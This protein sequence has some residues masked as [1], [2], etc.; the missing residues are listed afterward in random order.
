[1]VFA[2][3]AE[4]ALL[5]HIRTRALVQDA[6]A[7]SAAFDSGIF[8][9]RDLI[10]AEPGLQEEGPKHRV[11]KVKQA[12]LHARMDEITDDWAPRI[13]A[14]T[15]FLFNGTAEV[16]MADPVLGALK[17]EITTLVMGASQEFKSLFEKVAL[18]CVDQMHVVL[19]SGKR[20]QAARVDPLDGAFALLTAGAVVLNLPHVAAKII[21]MVPEASVTCFPASLM[22]PEFKN[23]LVQG[24]DYQVNAAGVA[25]QF[26][27]VQCLQ[28][29]KSACKPAGTMPPDMIIGRERYEADSDDDENY[30]DVYFAQNIREPKFSMY[31]T[32][33]AFRW[34][35]EDSL[36]SQ[37]VSTVTA[38][39]RSAM[40]AI[41]QNSPLHA[42]TSAFLAVGCYDR[43]VNEAVR[44]ACYY[45]VPNI[46]REAG[47]PPKM[48]NGLP[49]AWRQV[50]KVDWKHL[51]DV[52]RGQAETLYRALKSI[53]KNTDGPVEAALA[54]VNR[55]VKEGGIDHLIR[56]WK[57][58]SDQS[59]FPARAEPMHFAILAKQ[60]QIVVAMLNAGVS[61]N[62]PQFPGVPS[63]L[64]MAERMNVPEIANA[65]RAWGLRESARR[66][67]D[68][69]DEKPK[70]AP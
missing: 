54:L 47:N 15:A 20:N 62:E 70:V 40:D 2:S 52:Y 7:L 14:L 22:G 10:D 19:G 53:A 49:E 30:R 31:C 64:E 41:D 56:P 3:L 25:L 36:G 68:S 39:E 29:I 38:I 45:N 66:M 16:L 26:S 17:Q 1:M 34:G 9:V 28:A 23:L 18:D 35:V 24:H 63:P 8:N 13:S 43:D 4:P 55:A 57:A 65:M 42:Y 51:A 27:R 46:V 59:E 32:P 12:S 69:M 58:E 11:N 6:V 33:T 61:A 21:D 60:P 48:G 50:Q 5:E 67:M 37:K 44:E